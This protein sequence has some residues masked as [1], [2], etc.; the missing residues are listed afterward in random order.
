MS[1]LDMHDKISKAIDHN[2][3]SRESSSTLQRPSTLLITRYYMY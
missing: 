2:E 1:L 3:Y